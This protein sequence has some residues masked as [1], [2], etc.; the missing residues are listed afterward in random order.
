MVPVNWVDHQE[1]PRNVPESTAREEAWSGGCCLIPDIQILGVAAFDDI[2][3]GEQVSGTLFLSVG[4][5]IDLQGAN[6]QCI[7]DGE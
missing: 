1:R 5:C 7:I 6:V 2:L 4:Y 3:A